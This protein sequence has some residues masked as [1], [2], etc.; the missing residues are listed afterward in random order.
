MGDA[1][2]RFKQLLSGAGSNSA[3]ASCE[4]LLAQ[5]EPALARCFRLCAI[6]HQFDTALL[7]ALL[8]ESSDT[9][10]QGYYESL[11]RLA[12]VN[13]RGDARALHD[14]ARSYLFGK[15]LEQ[16]SQEFREASARLQ[17]FFDSQLAGKEGLDQIEALRQ[18]MFHWIGADQPGGIAEFER[19]CRLARNANRL[20]GCAS[21]IALVHEYDLILTENSRGLLAY[22]EAKLAADR[23]DCKRAAEILHTLL[24]N[25]SVSEQVHMKAHNR[26]GLVYLAERQWDD[27]IA[28]LQSAE[29][30]AVKNGNVPELP[31]ILNDMAV[32]YSKKGMRERSQA[33]LDRS[34]KMAEK[35]ND[36]LCLAR[37]YN[38]LGTLHRS[39]NEHREAI[40]A[41]EKSLA[42]LAQAN[43]HFRR[44]AVYNNLGDEYSDLADWTKSLQF[45]ELSLQISKEAADTIGQAR[46]LT[47][48]MRV[49]WN[50]DRPS[51]AIAAGQLAA[52]Y[53]E[54]LRDDYNA[55]NAM[56]RLAR[57][58]RSEK[59]RDAA[60][61]TYGRA[62]ELY[63]KAGARSDAA[64]VEE[65]RAALVRPP[66]LPWW[67]W[68]AI[69]MISAILVIF[70]I[71]MIVVG[72]SR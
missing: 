17:V 54:T 72:A 53:F 37:D 13:I 52:N 35:E 36:L 14:T 59:R 6:P 44:A 43:D 39:H 21:A 57:L 66:G 22:H 33:L 70:A 65:E 20:A 56:L 27:A 64:N 71:L 25:R 18:R 45:F 29:K 69:V 42:Y 47:N 2:A 63:Q 7:K 60:L 4:L 51:E 9:Q 10:V 16:N 55:G 46:T 62:I 30:L 41:Y 8:P 61:E 19:L 5:L 24:A 23:N 68:A 11:S 1:L 26:L 34:I 49:Y 32:A 28:A 40:A 67:A 3:E 31:L 12:L 38:T 50:S 58:Y 48:L 15:W